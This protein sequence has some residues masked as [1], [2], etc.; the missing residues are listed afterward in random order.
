MKKKATIKNGWKV[1][2]AGLCINLTLGVLYSWSVIQKVLVQD[3]NWSTSD[4][5]LPYTVAIVAWAIALIFAG[6]LQD[7]IGPRKVVTLGAIFT[8]VGLILAGFTSNVLLLTAAFGILAGAGIGFAYSAVTPPALKWFHPSKK[9]M[10]TGIVVSGMG[11]ASIYIA[12]ITSILLDTYGV[13]ITFIVLGIF[14]LVV[15][16]PVAQLLTNPPEGYVPPEPSKVSTTNASK[17][18]STNN[19][20]WKEMIK[21][22]EFYLLWLMFALSSSAGLMI[23]G[24]IATIAKLQANLE[25]GFYLVGLLALFNAVGRPAAGILSDKIGRVPTMMIIFALQGVNMALFATYSTPLTIAIGTAIAGIGYGSILAL[26]PSTAAD[27]YGMKNFGANYG[28][29]YTAWGISGLIGPIIAGFVVDKTGSYDGAYMISA[30]LLV[31]ALGIA[32]ITK[33]VK[34]TVRGKSVATLKTG[35]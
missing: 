2:L 20:K 9:G 4:A 14:I 22:K 19:F 5:S 30:I 24:N 7:K 12:P 27:F 18:P 15:A 34:E 26:F 25:A 3:W 10:V 31:V 33:P 23:I 1:L 8:G 32:F 17:N 28:V 11:L 16:T 13:S 29:L 6:G 35:N 21:T